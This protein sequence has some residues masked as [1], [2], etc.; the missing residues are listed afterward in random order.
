MLHY[1]YIGSHAADLN[2]PKEFACNVKKTKS[3][4]NND[5]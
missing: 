4:L 5:K 2:H 1:F 3:I